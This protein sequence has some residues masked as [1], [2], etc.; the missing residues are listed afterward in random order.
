MGLP[1]E[2]AERKSVENDKNAQ[3]RRAGEE[4]HGQTPEVP[5]TLLV[6]QE[7]QETGDPEGDQL[8]TSEGQEEE[9]VLMRK[10]EIRKNWEEM[11]TAQMG[12][13]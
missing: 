4:E 1:Q 12:L 5:A 2:P 8:V 11:T 10:G 7:N 3:G 6:S 13:R 9:W